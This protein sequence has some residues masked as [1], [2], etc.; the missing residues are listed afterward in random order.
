[1][2]SLI[3]LYKWLEK[4]KLEALQSRVVELQVAV[5]EKEKNI[6]GVAKKFNYGLVWALH[7]KKKRE[8]QN[9]NRK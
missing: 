3:A 4:G 2:G 1:M 6:E 8:E 7:N 5:A 9:C